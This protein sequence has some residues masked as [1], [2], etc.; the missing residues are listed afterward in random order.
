MK[1]MNLDN[2]SFEMIIRGSNEAAWEIYFVLHERLRKLG[3]FQLLKKARNAPTAEQITAELGLNAGVAHRVGVALDGLSRIGC[4]RDDAGKFSL[5]TEEVPDHSID[6]ASIDFCYSPVF[7]QRYMEIYRQGV[8]FDINF[9][10]RFDEAEAELWDGILNCRANVLWRDFG[11]D[12]VVRPDAK[13]V[14]LA[15]GFPANL[16]ELSKRVGESGRVYGVD[17]SSYFVGLAKQQTAECKNIG[18]IFERDVNQS[19]GDLPEVVDGVIFAGALHFVRDVARFVR[20]IDNMT[21]VG[22]RVALPTFF[23]FRDCFAGPAFD[24]H[25]NMFTPVP[26]AHDSLYVERLMADAGFECRF[27]GNFGTYCSLYFEKYPSRFVAPVSYVSQPLAA[28]A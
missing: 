11:Q 12:W 10:L 1:A 18:G 17:A 23:S 5:I 22:A 2:K 13:V 8:L 16:V 26:P 20:D 19:M 24:M 15:F 9:A 27:R 7:R 28:S 4:L 25:R 6:T 14:D 3:L 21:R